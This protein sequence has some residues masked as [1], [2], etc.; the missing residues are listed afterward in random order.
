[1]AKQMMYAKF[2]DFQKAVLLGTAVNMVYENGVKTSVPKSIT[3][4]FGCSRGMFDV[5]LDYRQG[6]FEQ[7]SKKFP[8]GS[9]FNLD[10]TFEVT[11]VSF[12]AFDGKLTVKI[13]AEFREG[14]L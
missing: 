3:C 6:L 2:S 11:D 9:F 10:E 14:I 13:F 5:V 12:S 8:S 7:I 1:M 4:T